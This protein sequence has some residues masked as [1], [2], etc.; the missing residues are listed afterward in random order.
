VTFDTVGTLGVLYG[1]EGPGGVAL[2]DTWANDGDHPGEWSN[3]SDE[4]VA[5]PPA[6]IGATIA[7]DRPDNAYLLFGGQLANGTVS[8]ETWEYQNFSNW[9]LVPASLGGPPAH[10]GAA[11]TY[12]AADGYIVLYDPAG[13]GTTWKFLGGHWSLLTTP[14]SPP[15]RS[16]AIFVYDAAD[17]AALLYGGVSGGVPRNDT[18]EYAGDAWREV[19]SSGGAPPPSP[20]PV[21]AYDPRIPGVVVYEGEATASTWEFANGHWSALTSTGP[22]TP[23][24]RT[25]AGF[26]YDSI[27]GYDI[28]FGGFAAGGSTVLSDVYGWSVPPPQLDLTVTPAPFSADEVG[29]IAATVAIPVVVAWFL[30]RRPPRKLPVSAP[31]SSA[32]ATPGG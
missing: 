24:A 32:S 17:R 14:T 10:V 23:P 8:E 5:G 30:R 21:A 31:Q 29:L 15:E 9:T 27:V 4:I 26:Y 6:L 7:Y 12:D 22:G 13:N 28:L 19:A 3:F 2:N 18:W 20:A 1:G 16:G 25:G 11:V